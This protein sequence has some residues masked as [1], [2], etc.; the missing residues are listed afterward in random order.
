[1]RASSLQDIPSF[2]GAKM[3]IHNRSSCHCMTF[4]QR[5]V[6]NLK[7]QPGTWFEWVGH[8]DTGITGINTCTFIRTGTGTIISNF[9]GIIANLV[10]VSFRASITFWITTEGYKWGGVRRRNALLQRVV[11]AW[12]QDDISVIVVT[13]SIPVT[14]WLKRIGSTTG[15]IRIISTNSAR[16]RRGGVTT[17]SQW[18]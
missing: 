12:Q 9:R 6:T 16:S 18:G 10:T 14:T 8:W 11:S 4:W 3:K 2:G 1:M 17:W 15:L 5:N 13:E 7:R